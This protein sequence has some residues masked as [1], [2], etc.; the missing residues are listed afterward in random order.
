MHSTVKFSLLHYMV[1]L[2][3]MKYWHTD[4]YTEYKHCFVCLKL[5]SLLGNFYFPT[6]LSFMKLLVVSSSIPQVVHVQNA[7]QLYML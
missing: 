2:H 1:K 6:V 4:S 7:P 5:K 3:K